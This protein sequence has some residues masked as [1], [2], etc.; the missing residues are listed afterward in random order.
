MKK[1]LKS[2][3]ALAA[4]AVVSLLSGCMPDPVVFSEVFQLGVGEKLYTKYNIWYTDPSDISCLNI[5]QGAFIPVGTEI[6]P[7]GTDFW[8]NKIRFRDTAGKEY[9]IR[10]NDGYRICAMHDYIAY[11]FTKTPP[12]EL[13]AGIPEKS[14]SRIR[15][16]EVVQGMNQHEVLLAYGPPPAARTPDLRNETWIYWITESETVRL[17]FRDDTVRQILNINR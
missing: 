9:A 13:F 5:Q 8:L 7:L 1:S 6:E 15:R 16:G 10:F 14:L 4:L 3:V 2:V 12:E 17:V 11:T